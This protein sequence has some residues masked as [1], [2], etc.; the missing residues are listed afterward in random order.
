[1]RHLR[2]ASFGLMLLGAL[3]CHAA[4][5]L[6]DTLL[7]YD[8]VWWQAQYTKL[9]DKPECQEFIPAIEKMREFD[10]FSGQWGAPFTWAL[11][12]YW[13]N[14]ECA[15][16]N[17]EEAL[18]I[19]TDLAGRGEI[20]PA[21]YLAQ[22][23]HIEY[24]A[25]VPL[26][27]AWME[28]AKNVM[29]LIIREN[30]RDVFHK[31]LAESFQ[32]AGTPLSPQLEE[33]FT[34]GEEMLNGDADRLYEY[35][36]T[37]LEYG[38]NPEDNVLACRWLYA[39]ERKGH[40]QARFHLARI[41][42]LGDGVVQAPRE[43][44]PWLYFSVNKDKN[45]DALIFL[46]TLLEKGGVFKRDLSDAYTALLRAKQM[47]AGV[48]SEIVQLRNKL[49]DRDIEH[50]EWLANQETAAITFSVSDTFTHP[51]TSRIAPQICK[52]SP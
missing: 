41:H 36:M 21:I 18:V 26:T 5:S 45:I 34:W 14:G 32:R 28:R 31:P 22:L 25:D 39:A 43:A 44:R 8:E 17:Q 23:Y 12:L 16:P 47:G 52:F 13:E 30:W 20:F 10:R 46:S 33:I 6:A 29:P 11:G 37:L 19:F 48:T 15:D 40:V 38:Q 42:I 51:R 9:Y 1:M 27:K 2:A 3:A 49:S 35:G 4:P 24:G 50:A 7:A